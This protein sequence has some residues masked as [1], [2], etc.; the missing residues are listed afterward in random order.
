MAHFRGIFEAAK[1]IWRN[2]TEFKIAYLS[3]CVFIYCVKYSTYISSMYYVIRNSITLSSIDLQS[4]HI[5]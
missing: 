3:I 1:H 4:R 2:R 5:S